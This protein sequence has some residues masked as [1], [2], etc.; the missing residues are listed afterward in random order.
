MRVL[1]KRKASDA[2]RI[3]RL[4][5]AIWSTISPCLL[6]NANERN[7]RSISLVALR[8]TR[9]ARF[10]CSAQM[11]KASD[12][13]RINRLR[14]AISR[15]LFLRLRGFGSYS[16]GIAVTDDLE[17]HSL[18]RSI[19]HHEGTALHRSKDLA[20]SIPCRHG[21]H[22]DR[23][24]ASAFRLGRLCSHLSPRG[25]RG[26]PATMLLPRGSLCPDFPPRVNRGAAC[27]GR[28]SITWAT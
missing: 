15:I 7:A 18:M 22:P 8:D 13:L 14:C 19:E 16:S 2:L 20:V 25:V 24:G 12:A 28:H 17:R 4:R 23:S 11:R 10:A 26:L 6:G 1:R 27:A 3:T 9:F 21:H 5:C